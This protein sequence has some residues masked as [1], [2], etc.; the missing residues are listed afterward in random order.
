MA[1][2][3]AETNALLAVMEGRDDDAKEILTD[4][5]DRGLIEF[6]G[7]LGTLTYLVVNELRRRGL[8]L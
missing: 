6:D 1:A 5:T 3:Y 7:Q 4:S 2:D 8:S